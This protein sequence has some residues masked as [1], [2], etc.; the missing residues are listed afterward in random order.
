VLFVLALFV[1]DSTFFFDGVSP[2]PIMSKHMKIEI[3]R[4]GTSKPN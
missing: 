1:V 2:Q 3:G 4:M